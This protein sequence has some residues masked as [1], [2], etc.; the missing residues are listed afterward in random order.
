MTSRA[1]SL[2]H[3]DLQK[4]EI[5]RLRNE[6]K[7]LHAQL[8]FAD[9]AISRFNNGEELQ[10]VLELNNNLRAELNETSRLAYEW[11]ICHDKLKAGE[12]Y[13]FPSPPYNKTID[14][15]RAENT[16]IRAALA[17]SKSPCVYCSL[18]A[19]EWA[20]CPSGFPGCDRADDAMGCP[21]LGASLENAEL[22]AALAE[23]RG[24][25]GAFY[26]ADIDPHKYDRTA[27]WLECNR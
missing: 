7:E 16:R 10:S 14:D 27:K 23:A 24:L 22:R 21:E 8:E 26:R 25:L 18:P 6:I 5:E 15:L 19:D 13:T 1:D 12:P 4:A 9:M 20:K 3:E 11:M 2:T 17:N